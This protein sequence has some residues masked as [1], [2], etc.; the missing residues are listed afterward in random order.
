MSNS[1]Q[2]QR[3]LF[4]ELDIRGAVVGLE[5]SYHQA[6]QNHGYPQVIRQVLGE[7]MAA[8]ALLSTNLKFEG[9]LILQVAG[10]DAVKVLMAECTDQQELRAIA[11]F[12]GE[13]PEQASFRELVSGGQ[14]AITIQPKQGQRYQGVVPLE[15]DTLSQCLESYFSASEQLPTQIMLAAD[16]DKAAGMMVQVLPVSGNSDEDWLRIS[17]LTSTLKDEELL[18]LDNETLLYRL[19]HEETCRLFE[20]DKVTFRCDCSRERSAA[21]LRYMSREELEQIIEEE[22]AV[23]VNCQF[24]NSSYAFGRA[25]L[26]QVFVPNDGDEQPPLQH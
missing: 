22:G 16:G 18:Y 26:D 13:L 4:D 3:I 24:C 17:H 23:A 15:G 5:D 12:D 8:A 9:R 6:L 2:I 11:R 20:A 14:M 10:Q 7:L 1:D 21:S 25:D 19:Y